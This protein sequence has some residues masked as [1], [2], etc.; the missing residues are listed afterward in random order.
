MGQWRGVSAALTQAKR[1]PVNTKMFLTW[2]GQQHA[3]TSA[4]N[5]IPFCY[6]GVVTPQ[7]P[8]AASVDCD[9]EDGTCRKRSAL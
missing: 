4:C 7:V 2:D 9:R 6:S 3:V 8:V 1:D 5:N